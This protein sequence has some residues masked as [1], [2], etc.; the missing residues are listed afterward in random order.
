MLINKKMPFGFKL[1]TEENIVKSMDIV[2]IQKNKQKPPSRQGE[3][4]KKQIKSENSDLLS[5][6][7]YTF[8]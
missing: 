5:N 1:E 3:I 6:E 7:N 8:N 4:L 2:K